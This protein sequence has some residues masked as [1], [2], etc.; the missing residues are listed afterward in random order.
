M[1]NH[2]ELQRHFR[3]AAAVG[4]A[5]IASLV[6]YLVLVEVLRAVFKPFHGFVSLGDVQTVRYAVFGA[7]VVVVILMR[8]V[9]P[10]LLRLA[11]GADDRAALVRLQ[12]ASILTMVLA[13]VPA[14]LGL[15]H[16]L[17]TGYNVD[18]YVLLAAS[19]VLV[20]MYFPRKAAWEEG[21]AR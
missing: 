10:L 19:L 17:V 7:A 18:F 1:F 20:F 16:F 15:G 3:P 6:L 9:R 12:R 4:A 11:P 8:V 2:D 5:V 14:I 21:G 13:E